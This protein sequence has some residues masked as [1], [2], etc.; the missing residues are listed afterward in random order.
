MEDLLLPQSALACFVW[1]SCGQWRKDGEGVKL[2]MGPVVMGR[3]LDS[4]V[5]GNLQ[6]FFEIGQ[7][8]TGI[9]EVSFCDT[10]KG[11]RRIHSNSCRPSVDCLGD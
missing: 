7:W 1:G 3:L 9:Y 6:V 8:P 4:C 2:D 5:A 11:K 10:S